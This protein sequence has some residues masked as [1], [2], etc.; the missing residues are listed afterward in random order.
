MA[1]ADISAGSE[2]PS[3]AKNVMESRKNE[4]TKQKVNQVWN[5]LASQ[6]KKVEQ[7]FKKLSEIYSSDPINFNSLRSEYSK[8]S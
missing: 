1:L 7:L 5:D 6:N 3:M 8:K 2:S 4:K